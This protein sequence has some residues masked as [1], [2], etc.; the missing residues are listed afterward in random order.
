[1]TARP[2]KLLSSMATRELLAAWPGAR[3]QRF[4]RA[5]ITEPP[6]ASTWPVAWV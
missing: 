1:M 6:V 2:L 4:A 3:W 5:V